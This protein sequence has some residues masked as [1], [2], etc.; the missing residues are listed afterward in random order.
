MEQLQIQI[1]NMEDVKKG[2]DSAQRKACTSIVEIGYILRKADD[3]QIFRQQGYSSIF[4]FA[5]QEYGWEQS[6]TSRFMAINRQYSQGGYSTI[7]QDKYEGYGQAKLTEMLTLPESIREEITSDMK[8]EDIR[9]LKRDFKAAEE[10]RQFSSFTNSFAPAHEKSTL[11]E[12]IKAMYNMEQY[13][14]NLDKL[15]PFVIWMEQYPDGNIKDQEVL[16][17]IMPSGFGTVR[18]GGCMMFFKKDMISVIKGTSK[19]TF[20][21][22]DFVNTLVEMSEGELT[23]CDSWY[24]R[25]F[26]KERP[27][28]SPK[29]QEND[30]TPREEQVSQEATKKV[31][32][33]QNGPEKLA[34]ESTLHTETV[35]KE[36]IKETVEEENKVKEE[37]N[38]ETSMGEPLKG[39]SIISEF[40]ETMPITY[41]KLSE[42]KE[43]HKEEA[44]DIEPQEE[45][46]E[47]E[48]QIIVP[49]LVDGECQYCAGN[50]DIESN[51]GEFHIH[52]TPTGIGRIEWNMQFAVMEFGYCPKCGKKLGD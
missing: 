33:E 34:K 38:D 44:T 17:A 23:D 19:E 47:V 14:K 1:N 50:K 32:N 52:M 36:K 40:T 39:Q 41:E 48:E 5:K 35:Q 37:E 27:N 22:Q 24:L 25:V 4:E 10:E 29:M 6:Q 21:Y 45:V 51:D 30:E 11:E 9:Q 8:R 42:E 15:W 2:I 46:N 20:S 3:A 43:E 18:A 26:G 16:M 13:A 7:L 49:D 31:N 28:T 12:C